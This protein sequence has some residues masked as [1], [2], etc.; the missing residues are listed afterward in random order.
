MAAKN[1]TTAFAHGQ[2][3]F[4]HLTNKLKK[5][6]LTFK[7]AGIKDADIKKKS[8]EENATTTK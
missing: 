4:C 1:W 3:K 6:N 2:K 5:Y 8:T 7:M